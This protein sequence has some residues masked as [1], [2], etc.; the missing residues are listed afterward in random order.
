MLVL[1]SFAYTSFNAFL[2]FHRVFGM[3]CD[4]VTVAV[5]WFFYF[6][7]EVRFV[8]VFAV[9]FFLMAG[10]VEMSVSHAFF[11]CCSGLS[12]QFENLS[13]IFLYFIALQSTTH[14]HTLNGKFIALDIT[15]NDF[16]RVSWLW[17]I[18]RKK[19]TDIFQTVHKHKFNELVIGIVMDI[20]DKYAKSACW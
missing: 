18:R 4:I 8:V 5:C 14:T 11:L 2:I 12:F 10:P 13:A 16:R 1:L 15:E 3:K 7:L 9:F 20:I 19:N 17:R 6:R